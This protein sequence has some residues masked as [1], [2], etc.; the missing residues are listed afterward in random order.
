[1]N[2]TCSI[3]LKVPTK[4]QELLSIL[5]AIGSIA[6]LCLVAVAINLE[7]KNLN[8]SEIEEARTY[9]SGK[10]AVTPDGVG[11]VVTLKR[12]SFTNPAFYTLA[13]KNADGATR[14]YGMLY[15]VINDVVSG[16]DAIDVTVVDCSS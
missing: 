9:L 6:S 14:I 4:W 5:L 15:V 3:I 10:C 2:K 11:R 12:G 16:H 8:A 13:D 1:M 7:Y